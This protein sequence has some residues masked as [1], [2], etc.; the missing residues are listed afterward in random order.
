MRQQKRTRKH[1]ALPFALVEN[2]H[3]EKG[4]LARQGTMVRLEARAY[5]VPAVS[6]K[7][8]RFCAQDVCMCCAMCC[9][10]ELQCA[11]RTVCVGCG[12]GL[13]C[14]VA[15]RA[16]VECASRGGVHAAALAALAR[17][18]CRGLFSQQS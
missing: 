10:G 13:R 2:S 3:A 4:G 7:M 16:S 17:A 1:K 9:A 6:R 18:I 12:C 8:T 11:I 5:I 15:V 14:A